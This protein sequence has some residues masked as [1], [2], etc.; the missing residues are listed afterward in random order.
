LGGAFGST[1]LGTANVMMAATLA[2]G[3]TVIDSAP[4]EPEVQD[5]AQMLVKMGAKIEGVGTSRLLIEGVEHLESVEHTIIGDRIEAGTFMAASVITAGDI[6]IEGTQWD[7]L[8]AV[9]HKL[10]QTGADIRRLD[11]D[12]RVRGARRLRSVDLTTLPFPG[13]PTD[14]QAQVMAILA[15][16]DGI[17]VVTEKIFPDR[18]MHLAELNRMGA[19]IRKEGNVAIVQG[20]E[21]LSG[22]PVMA[23]DLRASA[24]LIVAGLVA[25]GET[26]VDRVYHLDRGY[27]HLDEKLSQLGADIRR[28]K[29]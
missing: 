10:R 4:A 14:L 9:I 2:R 17:S 25:R 26:V 16:G 21:T 27:E 15:V 24:A 13:F 1:V 18:F 28:V 12:I 29:Q 23:S 19:R 11:G 20:V 8:F 22:A 3:T 6:T 5:L 7:H